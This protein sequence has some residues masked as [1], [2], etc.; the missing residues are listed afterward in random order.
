MQCLES[1]FPQWQKP[2]VEDFFKQGMVDGDGHEYLWENSDTS[3]LV[4]VLS[5]SDVAIQTFFSNKNTYTL[6][7]NVQL[8]QTQQSQSATES[9]SQHM[10]ICCVWF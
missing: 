2:E 3:S 8:L 7:S 4:S 6:Q 5:V 9:H 10:S 1:E